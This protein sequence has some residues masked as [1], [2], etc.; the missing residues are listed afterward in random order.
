MSRPFPFVDWASNVHQSPRPSDL[1]R[2]QCRKCSENESGPYNANHCQQ[3][4]CKYPV[5]KQQQQGQTT[6]GVGLSHGGSEVAGVLGTC[7]KR[8]QRL[9]SFESPS[10]I[11]DAASRFVMQCSMEVG[12]VQHHNLSKKIFSRVNFPRPSRPVRQYLPQTAQRNSLQ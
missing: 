4:S 10:L 11:P 3:S 1:L 7:Q 5:K 6:W 2:S 8:L 12:E 9:A